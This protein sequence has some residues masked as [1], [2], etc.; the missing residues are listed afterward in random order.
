MRVRILQVFTFLLCL[1]PLTAQAGYKYVHAEG[2][3]MIEL[4]DAP[5]ADTIWAHKVR[6]PYLDTP[7]KF[8]NVGEYVTFRRVDPDTGDVFD[9]EIKFIKAPRAFLASL[10]VPEIQEHLRREL[11]ELRLHNEKMD[12]SVGSDTLKWGIYSGFSVNEHNEKLYNIV[13]FLV[14][15]ESMTIV[16]VRFGIINKTYGEYYKTLANSI[17]F[18]GR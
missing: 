9:V 15:Q 7:P 4:P 12:V 1:L 2:E 14:G 10:K 18:L 17:K 16:K 8:G 6:V 11:K 5:T 13:H 3:Y